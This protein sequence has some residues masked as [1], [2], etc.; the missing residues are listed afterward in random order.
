MWR[1]QW[2]NQVPLRAGD[3]A[4]LVNW[5]DLQISHETTGEILYH[6]SWVTNHHLQANRVED[7]CL[8]PR[9]GR[10]WMEL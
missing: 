10:L 1:W 9:V 4:L 3:D 2:V 6:N 5:C 8:L 7:I